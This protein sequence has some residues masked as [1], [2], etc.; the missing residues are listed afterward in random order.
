MGKTHLKQHKESITLRCPTDLL[1]ELDKDVDEG[2]YEDR[3]KAIIKLVKKGREF[4][5]LVEI[6]KDP[7]KKSEFIAKMDEML[8]MKDVQQFMETITDQ[9]M[10]KAIVFYANNQHDKLNHQLLLEVKKG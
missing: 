3:S 1:D 6:S 9:S 8:Q 10:L 7:E 4:D 2:K 5:A